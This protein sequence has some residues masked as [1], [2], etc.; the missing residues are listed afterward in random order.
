MARHKQPNRMKT[1]PIKTVEFDHPTQASSG[2]CSIGQ[3]WA[4]LPTEQSLEQQRQTAQ[5]IKAL[6]KQRNAAIVAHYYVDGALQ[7]L[8]RETGGCVG[9][10]LEMARFGSE[11]PA[12]TLIVA[13]VRFMGETAKIL[14][15]E[16]TILMP[17]GD[18]TCSLD[19]GC[20]AEEFS[21]F[22][23]DHPDRTVVVYANTSAAVK[24]RADWVVTSS[25]GQDI[26]VALHARG[27]K[28]LW[29]PDRH[30]GSYIQQQTGA[31]MLLWQGSCVVHD[32]FKADELQAL[33][34]AHPEAAILVHPESPAAV[35]ALADVVGS[36]TQLIAA[37]GKLPTH[38][39]IVATDQGI[40]HDMR[41]RYLGK[42][43]L[44]APTA[45]MGGTCKSC[46]FCPW[47]AMNSLQGVEQALLHN[48]G[49]IELDA[50]LGRAARKPIERMLQFAAAHKQASQ[51]VQASGELARDAAL[52]QNFGP[53]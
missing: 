26:V 15:P 4:K 50:E 7:D 43:F 36:T 5:R 29:A 27:E 23:D 53:A 47:M 42:T 11:H 33:A 28:I 35:T 17:D 25:V 6:L 16:K 10:S 30:L 31:D 39:F 32:E 22:C 2:Q 41:Q 3:A 38:T 1:M 52:F 24:A 8:A 9:D 20:P 48:L 40:L 13:G 21:Q 45:G 34:D 46:A 12:T 44:A 51:R 19:L 18:A 14:S 49:A 37:V